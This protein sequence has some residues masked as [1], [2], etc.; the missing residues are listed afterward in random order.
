MGLKLGMKK[1]DINKFIKTLITPKEHPIVMGSPS[2]YKNEFGLN[3]KK[4]LKNKNKKK[5]INLFLG[6]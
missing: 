2:D 1:F 6:K 4:S 5:T 3:T